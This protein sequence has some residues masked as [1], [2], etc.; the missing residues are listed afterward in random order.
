[1]IIV[2]GG[3]GFIGSALIWKLNAE[4]VTDILVADHMADGSKWRN[5]AKRQIRTIIYKDDLFGWLS[6][7]ADHQPIEAIF[8]MGASSSTVE[9]DVDY[10]MRNN[11]NYSIGL[12]KFCSQKQIPLIYASS[13][14]TYGDGEAGFDDLDAG[15]PELVPMHP[16]GF[17]KHKF[18]AYALAQ[19]ETPPFWAGLKF[20]NVYGP[21]EYHKGAQSSVIN[22]FVPQVKTTGKIKLFKSY[23]SDVADGEQKRDFVYV[24][25]CVDV[26]WH[27]YQHTKSAKSGVYNVGTGSARTFKDLAF[28]VFAA[29]DQ[30][31]LVEMTPMPELL[32][33]QYQYFTEAKMDRLRKDTGYNKTATSLETGVLDYVRNYLL[34]NDPYL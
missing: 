24:K 13:A 23:R 29:M 33:G 32:R 19:K 31:A 26:M 2:T 1:M 28:A 30:P 3:A 22:Q 34:Q 20:F 15:T 18:D 4:G 21:N 5:L 7:Q 12:W 27:L 25:D 10:L 9:T 8:H 16:Y 14:S 17:S 6:E 11:L